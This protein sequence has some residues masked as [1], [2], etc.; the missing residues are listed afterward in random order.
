M[1]I[2]QI[3]TLA[4]SVSFRTVGSGPRKVLFFHGFP[5]SSSQV[6]I[7][8]H[9]AEKRGIE[10]LC[11]DRP[12][13]HKT[14]IKTSDMLGTTLQIANELT[15]Q[16]GWKKFEIVTVSGGTPYGLS[17]AQQNHE[18]VTEVRVICGLGDLGIPEIRNVFPK[19][20]YAA[21]K[22]LPFI[23]QNLLSS[24]FQLT[25]LLQNPDK[26]SPIIRLFFPTSA[27]DDQCLR[28]TNSIPSLQLSL[29]EAL[30]QKGLGPI[31]DARVF[32]SHW[33]KKFKNFEMPVNFWHGNE[34]VIVPDAVSK[35][36]SKHIKNS[37]FFLLHKEGHLS[38]PIRRTEDIMLQ[39]I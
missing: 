19:S 30:M 11:F 12:G 24:A 8:E 29:K 1:R 27:A 16:Q 4:G 39:K 7:F 32:S 3:K 23:H 38:L 35:L 20:S 31:Q 13:Y 37:N 9:F 17:L 15:S 28:E 14:K 21:L 5:G 2:Q 18:K 36:M 22:L 6:R 25:L 10:A 33:S 26:R 34:D